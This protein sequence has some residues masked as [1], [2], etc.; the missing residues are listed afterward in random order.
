VISRKT[1][2]HLFLL[3]LAACNH[4]AHAAVPNWTAAQQ[5]LWTAEFSLEGGVRGYGLRFDQSRFALSLIW[6]STGLHVPD[7]RPV[8]ALAIWNGGYFEQDL[9]PSGLLID[10]GRQAAPPN[11]GS[12]LVIFGKEGDP[13]RLV[14]YRDRSD[15]ADSVT[16]ALQIW[17]FLI[18]PGGGAGIRRDDQKRARRSAVGLDASGR[19]LLLAVI[20]DGV[21]LYRLMGIAR[22]LGAVVAANLDGGPSTGFG[23]GLAPAWSF[24]S[25]TLVSNA[26][27]LRARPSLPKSQ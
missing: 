5:G 8:D 15:L 14:R 7:S 20:D 3:V 9:R 22:D 25:Q 10:Q 12:G 18:E 23:L 1:T 19:G 26:L 4:A 21:S 11:S 13:M 27:V 17:P 24:P 16:S 2:P 6:S